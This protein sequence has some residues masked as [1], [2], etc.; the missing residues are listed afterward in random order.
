[1]GKNKAVVEKI[2]EVPLLKFARK[3]YYEYGISVLEDR[4]FPDFRDGM[5]PV[6]RRLL[7][8]SFEMGIRSN[9][10]FVKSARI[11]G[12]TLGLYHPHGDSSVYG[13]L[14]KM[15]NTNTAVP[16]FQGEGNWGSLSDKSFAA[17]RY[18]EARLSKFAD[19]VLFNKFYTPVID[20]VPNYDGSSKEPLLLPALLPIALINGRFGIAPGAQ[21]NIPICEYKSILRALYEIYQGQEITPE[22]LYKTLKFRSTYGGV[23]EAVE[24]K[25]DKALRES[26]FT[27]PEGKVTLYSELSYDEK[28]HTVTVS[29]FA[30]DSDME[31]LIVSLSDVEGIASVQDASSTKD[32]YGKLVIQ[33]KKGL[34]DKQYDLLK[35]YVKK[36]LSSR[37]SYVL[38]FTERYVDQT[39]QSAAKV[40]PMSLTETLT[41]W[42][43]WRT[44]LERKACQY[45]INEDAKEIRR[46]ELLLQA[47][48]LIDF[49]LSLLK[50]EKLDTH[51]VY[52]TYSKKAKCTVDEAKYVFSRPIISLRKLE[53]SDLLD[54]KKKVE[55]N[56]AK[57]EKRYKNPKP[58]MA[59]QLKEWASL[60]PKF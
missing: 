21:T 15:T 16:L 23:E 8:A 49:I 33:F 13:A 53:K 14:V 32:Y 38:N 2:K 43:E 40:V 24:D 27:S 26:V 58:F 17:M 56:K 22:Y 41:R 51:Q 20:F 35:K 10:K 52:E 18:T 19:E 54:Q 25:E 3:N 57:L 5:N 12:S 60:V 31:K 46:L 47:V 37:E 45:W 59:E 42:I 11:V 29:K 34:K 9:A 50:N 6:N 36:E 44:A 1:M 55:A 30:R 4:A 48:D 28:N 39:G 7:W